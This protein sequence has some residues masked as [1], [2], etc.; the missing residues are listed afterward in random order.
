MQW[1]E[2]LAHLVTL[3]QGQ[4]SLTIDTKFSGSD[5]YIHNGGWEY[6]DNGVV[7]PDST[8]IAEAE[9]TFSVAEMIARELVQCGVGLRDLFWHLEWPL[10]TEEKSPQLQTEDRD[11]EALWKKQRVRERVLEKMVMGEAYEGEERGKFEGRRKRNGY[12]EYQ[13]HV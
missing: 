12:W 9:H 10:S 7:I 1:Q 2:T 6:G 13:P 3:P 4:L 8:Y 11:E 5:I